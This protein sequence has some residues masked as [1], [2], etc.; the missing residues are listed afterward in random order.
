MGS[1]FR[2]QATQSC[3]KSVTGRIMRPFFCSTSQ[4]DGVKLII[5]CELR[6]SQANTNKQTMKPK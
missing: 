2:T 6:I 3:R 1:A 5:K 4:I